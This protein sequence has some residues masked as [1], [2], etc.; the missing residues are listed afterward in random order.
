MTGLAEGQEVLVTVQPKPAAADG[1]K[2]KEEA[3]WRYMEATG[4][5]ERLPPAEQT[6]DPNFKPIV[7][8]GE[9]LSETIIR[10][11]R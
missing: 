4:R 8:E 2:E 7:I 11:R 5:L 9:P 1:D 6:P 3:F 10:E